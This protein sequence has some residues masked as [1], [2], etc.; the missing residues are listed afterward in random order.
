[1]SALLMS[2]SRIACFTGSMVF[3]TKC[4]VNCW[5]CSRVM[6]V[7]TSRPSDNTARNVVL[8]L[9][10]NSCLAAR[11]RLNNN[12]VSCS[13][14]ADNFSCSS[15]QQYKRWSKSSPPKALLPPVA[16]TWNKPCSKRKMDTSNVP[17]PK[18]NTTNVPSGRL[19][20]PYAMAAAVGSLSKRKTFKPAKRAASLVAWRWASS[21]YAGTVITAPVKLPPKLFSARTFNAL[22]ISADTS[23]GVF[24][25]MRVCISMILSLS[26]KR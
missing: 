18:S 6:L 25:P 11:M 7:S 24:K 16:N 23:I 10:V 9:L 2:A 8:L 4:C 21:K 1:M 22:R 3:I 17:P 12:C 26:V 14:K 15:S 5:K 13:L 20:K 19:S